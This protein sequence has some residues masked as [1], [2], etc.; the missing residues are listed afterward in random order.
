MSIQKREKRE[1]ET[2]L[3]TERN[4][5]V[6]LDWDT[7][8][9]GIL[10]NTGSITVRSTPDYK[11]KRCPV[12]TVGPYSGNTSNLGEFCNAKPIA[13]HIPTN[14]IYIGDCFKLLSDNLDGSFCI[15][16]N[17]DKVCVTQIASNSLSVYSTRGEHIQ[18]VGRKDNEELEFEYLRGIAVRERRT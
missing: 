11:N 5:K 9:E 8:L 10:A 13:I 12:M 6:E 4:R 14:N 17:Q 18:S 15:C 7:I 1:L 16:I 2:R 3:E